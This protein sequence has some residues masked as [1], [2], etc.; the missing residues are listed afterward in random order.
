MSPHRRAA[1]TADNPNQ[2]SLEVFEGE[3][4]LRFAASIGAQPWMAS[5]FALALIALLVITTALS[6]TLSQPRL[7]HDICNEASRFAFHPNWSCAIPDVLSPRFSLLRDLPSIYI[8][9]VLGLTPALIL[10][11]WKGLHNLFPSM[12]RLRELSYVSPASEKHFRDSIAVTNLH[13]RRVGALGLPIFLASAGSMFLITLGI[14]SGIFWA[15]APDSLSRGASS[16]WTKQAYSHWWANLG[17]HPAS[18]IIYFLIGTVGIYYIVIMNLVG[19]RVVILLRQVRNDIHFG[20]SAENVD[21]YHGWRE[22][23][24][25]LISTYLA[26]I[27]HSTALAAIIV[28]LAPSRWWLAAPVVL[29]WLI[30]V[31]FY[32]VIPLRLT[33]RSISR[34]KAQEEELMVN[35]LHD[36]RGDKSLKAQQV[37]ELIA[38]RLERVH[39]IRTLPFKRGGRLLAV[40]FTLLAGS[41]SIYAVLTVWYS[42]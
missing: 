27:L 6:G 34:Y 28:V 16:L 25:V 22:A 11:Q 13:I 17:N 32:L 9:T 41:A 20:A 26:T 5:G 3:R 36:L 24:E 8:A 19:G 35:Q 23:R 7:L 40:L 38:S 14:H 2:L 15:L 33:H 42:R 1:K 39:S 10:R 4:I 30:V 21:G 37:R 31:P 18:G 29:Q 12:S